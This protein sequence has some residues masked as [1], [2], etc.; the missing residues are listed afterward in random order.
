MRIALEDLIGEAGQLIVD[1]PG[2]WDEALAVELSKPD[3]PVSEH[4]SRDGC[5]SRGDLFRRSIVSDG[6]DDLPDANSIDLAF[7]SES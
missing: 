5:C 3:V 1:D 4:S 6:F 2:P 7:L